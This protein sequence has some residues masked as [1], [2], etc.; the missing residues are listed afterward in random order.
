MYH[1]WRPIATNA[2]PQVSAWR[3]WARKNEAW[4]WLALALLVGVI[5]LFVL[6]ATPTPFVR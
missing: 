6:V 4:I 3:R 2:T 5:L 1:L